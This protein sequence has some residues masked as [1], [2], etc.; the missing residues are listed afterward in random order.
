[1]LIYSLVMLTIL[2]GMAS[3]AVDYGRVQIVKAELQ[4]GIDAAAL[5]GTRAMA[6][7]SVSQM[8]AVGTSV[9]IATAASNN[10]NGSGIAINSADVSFGNWDT[11]QSPNFSTTRTPVNAMQVSG[12][13]DSVHGNPVTLALGP[14]VGATTCDVRVSSI[15]VIKGPPSP[16]GFAGLNGVSFGSLGVAAKVTGSLVSNGDVSVGNP[17]GVLVDVTQNAQSFTGYV[18]R[19][20]LATITGSTGALSQSLNYPSV[21]L[22]QSNNNAAIASDLDTSNNFN[23]VGYTTIPGGTYVVHNLNLLAGLNLQL[24]GPVTFYVTGAVNIAVNVNL[25]GSSTFTPSNF[26]VKVIKG[27]T[28]NFAANILAPLNMDLYAPDSDITLNVAVSQYSGTLIGKTLAVNVPAVS[29]FI[30]VVPPTP[31]PTADLVQ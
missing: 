22:P 23:A 15:A 21:V 6:Q 5:A 16:Y 27:G 2:L 10:A 26:N 1:M 17:L 12:H 3:F 13:C 18:S 20:P 31:L 30:E 14:I 11:T 19:G 7:V 29:N 9:A 28:V 25:L 4:T 24:Q 8:S